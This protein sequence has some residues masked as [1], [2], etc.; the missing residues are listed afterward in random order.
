MFSFFVWGFSLRAVF[1]KFP[2]TF[3]T[4]TY[5]FIYDRMLI[6]NYSWKERNNDKKSLARYETEKERILDKISAQENIVNL[7]KIIESS[8]ESS[9]Q[10]FFQTVFL[11]PTII[12]TVSNM[13]LS[14]AVTD[15]LALFDK[16]TFSIVL[17]FATLAFS[18]YAIR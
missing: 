7:S 3:V 11:W 9:F 6:K 12:I 14:G 2:L 10:F 1:A 4:K 17:S 16:R 5:K 8:F 15:L 13:E 18:F